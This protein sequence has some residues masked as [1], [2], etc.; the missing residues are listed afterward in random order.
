[1]YSKYVWVVSLKDIIKKVL[2]LL[3]PFKKILN[4]P[5][6]KPSRT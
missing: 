1:M 2:Q 6:Y 4:E 5:N 3:M